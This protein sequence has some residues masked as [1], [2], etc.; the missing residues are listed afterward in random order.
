MATIDPVAFGEN[1]RPSTVKTMKKVNEVVDAINN[2]DP[3]SVAT[4]KSDVATLKDNVGTLQSQMVTANANIA[5]NANDI[6]SQA[7]DIA[8]I[9]VTLFTPIRA[10]E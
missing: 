9:K 2:L 5:K 6:A 4:L 3:A 1:L 7:T 10:D 8:S